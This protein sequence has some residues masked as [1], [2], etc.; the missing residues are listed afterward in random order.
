MQS[1]LMES[2][3]HIARSHETMTDLQ[4]DATNE[5]SMLNDKISLLEKEKNEIMRR[6][7][8]SNEEFI[9]VSKSN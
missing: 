7:S 6:Y 8:Q 5:L 9:N 3:T 2:Q 1:Q 4:A